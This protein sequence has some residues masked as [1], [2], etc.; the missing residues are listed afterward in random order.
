[1]QIHIGNL[2][3]MTTANQLANLFLPFGQV[4]SSRILASGPKGFSTRI[5][6][7]EMDNLRGKLAI[8]K[9]NRLLFMNFYIE[10]EEI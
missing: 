7:I 8:K 9:L 2:S 4:A 6:L 1:M 10:V 5:G 3:V